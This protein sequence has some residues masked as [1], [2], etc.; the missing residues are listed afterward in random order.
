M[1]GKHE[2]LDRPLRPFHLA[3]CVHDLNAARA[4]YGDLLNCAE[5]RSDDNWIDFNL[6]GHQFVCHL[7]A[8]MTGIVPGNLNLVDGDAVPVPHFGVVLP[9]DEW[10]ALSAQLRAA[11][12]DFLLEP[13]TRFAGEAGEQGTLFVQD[14]SGNVLEFKGFQDI[15]ELF[16]A[17]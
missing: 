15:G 11:G 9:M 4:F 1:T 17:D 2:A 12:V 6:Y 14:P 8:T 13:R 3:V 7:S 16:R 5:G 10:R